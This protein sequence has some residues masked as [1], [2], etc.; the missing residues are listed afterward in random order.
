MGALPFHHEYPMIQPVTLS[1]IAAVDFPARAFASPAAFTQSLAAFLD[2]LSVE[3]PSAAPT[4]ERTGERTGDAAPGKPLP[5]DKPSGDPLAW[6]ATLVPPVPVPPPAIPLAAGATRATARPVDIAAVPPAPLDAGHAA[7]DVS[8]PGNLPFAPLDTGR[9]SGDVAQPGY[10]PFAPVN[11]GRTS[12]DGAPPARYLPFAPPAP[13]RASGDGEVQPAYVPIEFGQ[14]ERRSMMNVPSSVALPAIPTARAVTASTSVALSVVAPEQV[15]AA[16]RANDASP[17]L[18]AGAPTAPVPPLPPST[19]AHVFAAAMR[20][21]VAA[22]DKPVRLKSD[23]T[24]LPA[25]P[26]QIEAQRHAIAA[27]GEVQAAPL[28]MGHAGWPHR[29]IERIEQMRDAADAGDTRIRLVP[30]A[31]GAIDVAMRREGDTVHV[32]FNAEQNATARLL[33]EAQPRLAELAEARGIRLGGTAVD[34]GGANPRDQ[35]APQPATPSAPASARADTFDATPT[36]A[37]IA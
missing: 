4:T 34:T 11:T 21:A 12:E 36:D 29:M 32:H 18:A 30:D 24:P 17:A 20:E 14:G 3:I 9:A 25:A 15:V 5:E 22:D 19:A 13:G 2:T 35:R 23:T 26:A 6:L 31:L 28:D 33:I 7:G 16:P 37:R 1:T 10:P 8:R 27:T